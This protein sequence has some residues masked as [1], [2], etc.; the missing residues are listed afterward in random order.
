MTDERIQL[1]RKQLKTFIGK[2]GIFSK[3]SNQIDSVVTEILSFSWTERRTNRHRYT[4]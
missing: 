4:L 1:P 3:K 2:A